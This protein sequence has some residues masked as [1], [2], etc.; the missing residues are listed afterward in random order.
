MHKPP[1]CD[2]FYPEDERKRHVEGVT[3]VGVFMTREGKFENISVKKSSGNTALDEAA[4]KCYETAPPFGVSGRGNMIVVWS[5][6]DPLIPAGPFKPCTDFYR[7]TADTLKGLP[8]VT[9]VGFLLMPNGNVGRIE[10]AQ[11]S[12]DQYL[13]QAAMTCILARHFD[14]SKWIILP[15]EGM[16]E[17]LDID[18]RKELAAAK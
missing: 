17:T 18:W 3:I 4:V 5:L 14:T 15:P 7:V 16:P 12:G 13:D 8:G 6:H 10:I 1:S 9:T 2:A 11:S